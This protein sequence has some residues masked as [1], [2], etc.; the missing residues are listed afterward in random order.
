MTLLYLLGFS[1]FLSLSRSNLICILEVFWD[2]AGVQTKQQ[3][4]S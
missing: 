1:F 4:K 3:P 2:E